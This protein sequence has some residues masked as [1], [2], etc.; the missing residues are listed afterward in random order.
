MRRLLVPLSLLLPCA[1]GAADGAPIAAAV[2]DREAFPAAFRFARADGPARSAAVAALAS[3]PPGAP[4]FVLASAG[5][6][7]TPYVVSPLGEG[8]GIDPDPRLRWDGVD[9]LTLVET[10]LALAN[11][12]DESELAVALDDIRYASG[13][14]PSFA[15]RLHLMIAQWIPDQIRKGYLEDVTDRFG[16]TVPA[17]IRYDA[18]VWERRAGALRALPW[19]EALEGSW[20]VPM[21]PLARALE[22]ADTLPEG[23]VLNVVRSPR[24]DRIN[25]ITH[26][27][28]IVVRDGRRYVRHASLGRQEVVD[29]PI[30]RFLARHAQMRRWTV[31]G[32]H[33]LALRDNRERV[34]SLAAGVRG[35]GAAQLEAPGSTP[36]GGAA[37][38]R[39]R[40]AP[41]RSEATAAAEDAGA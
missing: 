22:I 39:A 2:A 8:E 29:E 21:I 1:A 37:E 24:A 10:A 5:F 11:A 34:R 20:S 33:L 17:E 38:E 9:C 18:S 4:R 31:D 15:S 30:E 32:I 12:E 23:L 16:S 14:A 13:T 19:S 27:G 41:R 35:L 6:L 28:L 36:A 40:P 3:T 26:T 7:G 25:R